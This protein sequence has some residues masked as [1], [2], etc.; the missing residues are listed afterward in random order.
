MANFQDPSAKRLGTYQSTPKPRAEKP[1]TI[2]FPGLGSKTLPSSPRQA[3]KN[4][5]SN[6]KALG[7]A[8]VRM[9]RQVLAGELPVKYYMPPLMTRPAMRVWEGI[10]GRSTKGTSIASGTKR[11]RRSNART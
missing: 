3:G 2:N 1:R 8:G 7:K 9:S 6:V 11:K 10:H 4:V 5:V